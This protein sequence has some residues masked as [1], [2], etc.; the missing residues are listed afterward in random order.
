MKKISAQLYENKKEVW[1]LKRRKGRKRTLCCQQ[2]TEENSAKEN[3]YL[4]CVLDLEAA[5]ADRDW[6]QNRNKNLKKGGKKLPR[7]TLTV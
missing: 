2:V 3:A 6:L 4:N 5:V 7:A 1:K